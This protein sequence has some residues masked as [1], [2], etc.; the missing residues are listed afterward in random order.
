[1]EIHYLVD[2]VENRD[3]RG[4]YGYNYHPGLFRSG[5]MYLEAGRHQVILEYRTINVHVTQ[6]QDWT[7]A[8]FK[9]DYFKRVQ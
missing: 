7:S 6:D 4:H 2:G 3:F 1:M 5:E 9:V 8:I